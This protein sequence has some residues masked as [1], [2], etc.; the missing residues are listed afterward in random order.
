MDRLEQISNGFIE[1]K[2]LLA[3]A[4]AVASPKV[5]DVLASLERLI[6]SSMVAPPAAGRYRDA[7]TRGEAL[8]VPPGLWCD[9]RR[10]R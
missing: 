9:A 3:A 5:D 2:I 4:E 7:T 8:P 6:D 1:A 10:S